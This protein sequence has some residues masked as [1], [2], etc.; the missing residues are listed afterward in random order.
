[1]LKGVHWGI[2]IIRVTGL[3]EDKWSGG[4][5]EE[6]WNPVAALTLICPVNSGHVISF[7]LLSL[8]DSDSWSYK[9][10]GFQFGCSRR[11]I[12]RGKISGGFEVWA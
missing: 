11:L 8:S 12:T 5:Y 10:R 6:T 1:M 9:T 7:I 3:M 2:Q 4:R